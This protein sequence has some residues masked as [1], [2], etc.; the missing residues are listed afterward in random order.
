LKDKEHFMKTFGILALALTL[1]A[2]A[3]VTGFAQGSSTDS[4]KK[5]TKKKKRK[6]K[7][8]KTTDSK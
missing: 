6:K 8:T 1:F 3:A 7:S 4:T 2:G 5:T